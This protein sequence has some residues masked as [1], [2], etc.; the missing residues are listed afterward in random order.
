MRVACIQLMIRRN[1]QAALYIRR[2]NRKRCG[3]GAR[4]TRIFFGVAAFFTLYHIRAEILE[5]PKASLRLWTW[6][7][8]KSFGF[9]FCFPHII[10]SIDWPLLLRGASSCD[11]IWRQNQLLA[12]GHSCITQQPWSFFSPFTWPLW[13]ANRCCLNKRDKETTWPTFVRQV[14]L[15][16]FYAPT[17]PWLMRKILDFYRLILKRWRGF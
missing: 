9:F 7:S 13:K 10:L 15:Y 6:Q 1:F 3:N 17:R 5:F 16:L 12:A 2:N 11:Q 8:N 4:K 14:L